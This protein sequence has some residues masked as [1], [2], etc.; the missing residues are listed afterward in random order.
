MA[1]GVA[2]FSVIWTDQTS[3]AFLVLY[4]NFYDAGATPIH[5][6]LGVLRVVLGALLIFMGPRVKNTPVVISRFPV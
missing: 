1:I 2:I 4:A 6:L 3:H 5:R